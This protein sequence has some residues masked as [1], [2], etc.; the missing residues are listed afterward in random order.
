MYFGE[1]FRRRIVNM[2]PWP[3]QGPKEVRNQMKRIDDF[4]DVQRELEDMQN[5]IDDLKREIEE[6]KRSIKRGLQ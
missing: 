3:K 2:L 6:L 4:D 1:G 5:Q